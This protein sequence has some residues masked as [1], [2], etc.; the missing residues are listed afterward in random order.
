M[1]LETFHKEYSL[2][3]RLNLSNP[4]HGN[5]VWKCSTESGQKTWT[6]AA[7]FKTRQG[8]GEGK[9]LCQYWTS[10]TIHTVGLYQRHIT[11]MTN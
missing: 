8:S 5:T 7:I 6:T 4:L 3:L 2:S 9:N 1:L 10:L 11:E